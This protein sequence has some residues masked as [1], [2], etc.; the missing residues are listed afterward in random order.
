[1]LSDLIGAILSQV[2][3]DGNLRPVAFHSRTMS[4]AELNYDIYDKELLAIFCAFTQWRNYLEGANH[5]IIVYTDH[6]N[7]EYFTT[8]KVL[9]RRQARWAEYLGSFNFY[10]TYRSG[11]LGTKPDALTRRPDVYPRGGDGSRARELNQ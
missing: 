3:D 5:P 1:M 11:K 9:S 2:H 6:K 7:L 4:P 8:T 10:I